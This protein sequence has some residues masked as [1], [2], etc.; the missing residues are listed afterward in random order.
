[1]IQG[2]PI[3]ALS[4]YL[5]TILQLVLMRLQKRGASEI[6]RSHA[7]WALCLLFAHPGIL[8]IL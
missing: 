7:T 8:V 4:Q 5:P 2:L 6:F 1:M 3:N